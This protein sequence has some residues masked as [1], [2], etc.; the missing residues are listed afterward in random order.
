M[1][2]FI[3]KWSNFWAF[4][5]HKE[6]LNKAFENELRELINQQIKRQVDGQYEKIFDIITDLLRDD[7][8]KWEAVEDI[9][10]VW[11]NKQ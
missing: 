3:S 2:Q 6:Q 4:Q 1:E 10:D 8:D 5:P 9:M 11:N 7:I